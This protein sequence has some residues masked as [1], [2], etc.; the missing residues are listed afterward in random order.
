MNTPSITWVSTPGRGIGS[1][2]FGLITTFCIARDLEVHFYANW[3]EMKLQDALIRKG[4]VSEP[5]LSVD[6]NLLSF[7]ESKEVE[8]KWKTHITLRSVQNL[9]QHFAYT[10]PQCDYKNNLLYSIIQCFKYFFVLPKQIDVHNTLNTTLG[11][12]LRPNQT[13][14]AITTILKNCKTHMATHMSQQK[15]VL[16]VCRKNNRSELL[17]TAKQIFGVGFTVS[18]N[19]TN[20][21][22][23]ADLLTLKKCKALYIPWN[24]NFARMGVLMDPTRTFYVYNKASPTPQKGDI[25]ELLSYVTALR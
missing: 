5:I 11:I 4:A 8:A 18:L 22:D 21:G 3:S 16:I 24:S 7:L 6:Q 19:D 2:M 14:A 15:T 9:Y 23:L 13:Q 25:D 20:G 17:N 12:H 1:Q 10:R